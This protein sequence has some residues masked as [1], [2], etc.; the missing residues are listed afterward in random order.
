MANCP[1]LRIKTGIM[2]Q[3]KDIHC[4]CTQEKIAVQY[5]KSVCKCDYTKCNHY[6]R[7]G[8]RNGK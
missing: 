1:N 2:V 3:Y 5:M 7:Y 8:I 6:M 4:C